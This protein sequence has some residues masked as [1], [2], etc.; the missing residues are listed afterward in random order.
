MKIRLLPNRRA[1]PLTDD[2]RLAEAY[3]DRPA[4]LIEL[5]EATG[6][7]GLRA[8]ALGMLKEGRQPGHEDRHCR[9]YD[10]G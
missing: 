9:A 6:N 7:K 3:A 10:R 4:R 8:V 2:E 1:A 5:A